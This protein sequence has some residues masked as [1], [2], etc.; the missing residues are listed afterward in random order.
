MV[1][2]LYLFQ[3]LHLLFK[4]FF[5]ELLPGL[6]QPIDQ[7]QGKPTFPT[8]PSSSSFSNSQTL[9][10]PTVSHSVILAFIEFLQCNNLSYSSIQAYLSSIKSQFKILSLPL[11][12]F[13]H[14]SVVLTLRSIALNVPVLKKAKGIF[15]IPTLSSIIHLCDSLPSGLTYKALFLTAFFAFFH[16]SNLVPSSTA[17]FS[18]FLHLCRADVIPHSDFATIVVKWTKTLQKQS[19]FTTGQVPVLYPSPL[20]PVIAIQTMIA[21][22]PLPP[23]APLFALPQGFSYVPLTESK[24]RKTLASIISSLGLDPLSHSFHC[25]RRSGASLAFNSD[26]SLQAIQKQGTWS[27]DSVWSYIISNPLSQSSVS[28]AFKKL[29]Q[30]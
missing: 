15:D 20:C 19:Q 11:S 22:F 28:L 12:P 6:P 26:V 21:L 27:S 7:R 5:K 18:P 25:F 24:V 17:S 8:L 4:P 23:N 29:L 16:L 1:H 30:P 14:H 3:M 10:F 13:A 2:T 9:I